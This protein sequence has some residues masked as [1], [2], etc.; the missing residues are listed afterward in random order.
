MSCHI[1]N[2]QFY[3]CAPL[4]CCSFCLAFP[5]PVHSC[6]LSHLDDS[7]SPSEVPS[8]LGL[9][10]FPRRVTHMA[11]TLHGIFNTIISIIS[12]HICFPYETL[13]FLKL[14]SGLISM[15]SQHLAPWVAPSKRSINAPGYTRMSPWPFISFN[16]PNGRPSFHIKSSSLKFSSWEE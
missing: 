11:G 12:P 7:Y 4:T 3:A 8:L 15:C 1:T 14:R 9:L 13:R 10:Y 5:A 2:V 16:S 6:L